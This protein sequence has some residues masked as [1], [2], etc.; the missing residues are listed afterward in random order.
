MNERQRDLYAFLEERGDKWITQM[1]LVFALDG[2]YDV[3]AFCNE[4]DFHNSSVRILMTRDIREINESS[5]C[6]KVIISS[7]KGIKLA[8][9]EEFAKY[10]SKQYASVL[11]MLQRVRIKERKGQAHYNITFDE[12][13][14]IDTVESLLSKYENEN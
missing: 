1:D 10:I 14:E 3:S 5:E 2:W 6:E 4:V 11:R 13:A 9:E 12:N 7:S 8:N